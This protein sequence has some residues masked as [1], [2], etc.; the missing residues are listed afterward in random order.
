MD[1]SLQG[2]GPFTV[3]APDAQ[4]LKTN[5]SSTVSGSVNQWISESVNQ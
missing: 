3:F 4:A 1:I 2:R 5:A